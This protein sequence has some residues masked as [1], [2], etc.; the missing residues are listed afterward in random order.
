MTQTLTLHLAKTKGQKWF[1]S[2]SKKISNKLDK[3]VTYCQGYNKMKSRLLPKSLLTLHRPKSMENILER[4][5][6]PRF[7]GISTLG[8]LCQES[9]NTNKKTN[10]HNGEKQ[11][12]PS[13]SKSFATSESEPLIL[14]RGSSSFVMR[15]TKSESTRRRRF[16]QHKCGIPII[17]EVL[18]SYSYKR[19]CKNSSG[20]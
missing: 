12:L 14:S 16:S 8:R 19:G 6:R 5:R 3:L 7:E 13:K 10:S 4:D 17:P 15:E 20:V 11:Q 1:I 9:T 2:E 18:L